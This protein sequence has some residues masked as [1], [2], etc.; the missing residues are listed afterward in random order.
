VG[1]KFDGEFFIPFS[2]EILIFSVDT[3]YML[4]AIGGLMGQKDARG[5]VQLDNEAARDWIWLVGEYSKCELA[6]YKLIFP[7]SSDVPMPIL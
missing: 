3:V 2:I 6:R 1:Y 4:K 7:A 5:A